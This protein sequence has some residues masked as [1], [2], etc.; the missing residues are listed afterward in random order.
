MFVFV[1]F[2]IVSIWLWTCWVKLQVNKSLVESVSL[3][4]I[5]DGSFIDAFLDVYVSNSTTSGLWKINHIARVFTIVPYAWLIVS[6][7]YMYGIPSSTTPDLRSA[8]ISSICFGYVL[9]G[10]VWLSIMAAGYVNDNGYFCC[11]RAISVLKYQDNEDISAVDNLTHRRYFEGHRMNA[12][13]RMDVLRETSGFTFA[14]AAV[15]VQKSFAVGSVLVTIMNY[16][17]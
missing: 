17:A 1:T 9:Y 12:L 11:A 2:Y 7:M 13:L 16:K 4:S 14:G 3:Q 5:S 8:A 10:V 15:F 6:Y